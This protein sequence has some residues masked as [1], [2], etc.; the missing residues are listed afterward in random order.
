MPYKRNNLL[1]NLPNVSDSNEVANLSDEIQTA[2]TST[3]IAQHASNTK[4]R[5]K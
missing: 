2:L 4:S 1:L 3:T 5:S